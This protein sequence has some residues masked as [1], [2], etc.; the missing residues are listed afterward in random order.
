MKDE[1]V[2]GTTYVGPPFFHADSIRTH[3]Y[4]HKK[5]HISCPLNCFIRKR[6]QHTY[7]H[8]KCL[9]YSTVLVLIEQHHHY[10]DA[11]NTYHKNSKDGYNNFHPLSFWHILYDARIFLATTTANQQQQQLCQYPYR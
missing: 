11:R 6:K 7:T 5:P 9:F 8:R 3:T 4:T 1:R 2:V 10:V